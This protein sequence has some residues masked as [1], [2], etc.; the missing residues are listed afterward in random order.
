[1]TTRVV[2]CTCYS[3]LQHVQSARAIFTQWTYNIMVN[4]KR[5]LSQDT[6]SGLKI[7]QKYRR[8]RG[9]AQD[10]AG[11]AYL[12]PLRGGKKGRK[13]K[14]TGKKERWEK[15]AVSAISHLT[16]SQHLQWHSTLNH[17]SHNLLFAIL[18]H[19]NHWCMPWHDIGSN[20]QQ[21]NFSFVPVF[22]LCR[23]EQTIHKLI[24]M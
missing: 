4:I 12:G 23:L 22:I 10:P 13:G 19:S 9:F 11:K 1:M 21:Q 8:G 14:T 18:V 20:T 6:F 24:T 7:S 16:I 5:P 2:L 17:F 3:R 15:T